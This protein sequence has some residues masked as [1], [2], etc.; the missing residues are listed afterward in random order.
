VEV[1][2]RALG[3]LAGWPVSWSPH[4]PPTPPLWVRTITALFNST[5]TVTDRGVGLTIVEAVHELS[6]AVR[7]LTKVIEQANGMNRGDD[8]P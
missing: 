4:P 6:E 3:A 8:D 2:L 7:A 5:D 1:R